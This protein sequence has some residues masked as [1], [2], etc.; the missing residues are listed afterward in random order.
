MNE[1]TK[2]RMRPVLLG[3]GLVAGIAI[4]IYYF[5]FA[6][7]YVETDNAYVH[8]NLTMLA[9]EVSGRVIALNISENERVEQG[10]LLFEIDPEPYRIAVQQAEAA[11]AAARNELAAQQ[12]AYKETAAR[13]AAAREDV[14]YLES[15]LTRNTGLVQQDVVTESLLDE[16]RHERKKAGAAVS[17]AQ[18]E[19]ARIAATLGGNPELPV[20]RQAAYRRAEAALASARLALENTQVK[21]PVDGI[22]AKVNLEAGEMVVAGKAALALVD[23]GKPWIEANLKETQLASIRIGQQAEIR[24]DAYPD[25]V[26]HARVASIS[27]A[28]GSEF[29]LL[30]PQNATGNWVKVVQRIPV[31]LVLTDAKSQ[32]PLRAGLSAHV[33]IDVHDSDGTK[34]AGLAGR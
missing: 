15:E 17:A 26:W 6:G 1:E 10:Q 2:Q 20:E 23:A 31:R 18:S 33:E 19:M 11:L 8:A 28:T 22:A 27:P 5:L 30:P 24:V 4:A 14:A 34:T 13:L 12:A 7:R 16:L 3:A 32:P 29:S 21:S 25:R 9:P